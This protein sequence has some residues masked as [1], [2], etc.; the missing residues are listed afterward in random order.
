MSNRPDYMTV[1]QLSAVSGLDAG[2]LA[3]L[4]GQGYFPAASDEGYPASK[5]V[6]GVLRYYREWKERIEADPLKL[7][8]TE[9]R[10]RLLAEET[11]RR[12]ALTA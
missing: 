6:L 2:T 3:D 7:R 1:A 11:T 9:L 8:M 10:E 5:S 4:A 12:R